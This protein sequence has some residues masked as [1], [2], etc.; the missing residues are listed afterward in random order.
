M[1]AKTYA[2]DMPTEDEFD[3]VLVQ[4]KDSPH[5]LITCGPLT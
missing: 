1:R 3:V 5:S 4:Y 2:D